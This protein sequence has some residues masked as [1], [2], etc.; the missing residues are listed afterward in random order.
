MSYLTQMMALTTQNFVS[1][2]TG[3]A[4]AIALIRAFA[5]ASG[6]TVG[7]FWV[8]LT[9]S[10]LYVLL[11]LS[12]IAAL[13]L[14]WQGVPQNLGA[15]VDAT[16][17][18]GA[19][20]T[21]SQGPAASQIAIKQLGTNGGGFWNAN[22]SVPYENPTPLSNFLEVLY[23]LLISAALTHTFGRMVKDERQG[24]ALYA[25]MS[26]IFLAFVAIAYWAEA[27]GNP[28]FARARARSRQHGRQGGSL[29]HHQLGAVGGG[30]HGRLERLRQLHARQLHA[31]RRHDADHHD[32]ARRDHLRR[33]RLRPL[34]H[35][36]VRHRR[37]V[38]CRPDG[39]PHAGISRQEDRGQ[40]S[41]DGHAGHPGSAVDRSSASPRYPSWCRS[42][43]PACRMPARTGSARSCTSTRRRPRNNGSAFAGFTGNTLWYN[44]TG[45]LSMLVGRYFVI[46]PMMAIAGS[47]VAKKIV[48]ASAGTFPTHGGLFVG[49]LVGVILIIGGLTFFPALA[50]GPIAEH[51]AMRGGQVF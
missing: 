18:E 34:R 13:F 27:A 16:T 3:I 20:Q 49:L 39:R 44:T 14:V 19:K 47:L 30:D 24:W 38:H 50:L 29:R 1:A 46:I 28:H 4:L 41:Q 15:Y 37:R 40:G 36:A 22:S 7:N 42:A 8:D 43:C 17:L 6:N 21:L 33:R 31:A 12:L 35:A 32:A 45:G 2:A 5:R 11:P 26:V 25:A 10:T 51:F 9:R 23:I 48:P